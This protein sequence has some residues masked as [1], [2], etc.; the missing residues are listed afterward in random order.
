[1]SRPKLQEDKEFHVS[2]DLIVPEKIVSCDVCKQETKAYFLFRGRPHCEKC[3]Y[4]APLFPHGLPFSEKLAENV[5]DTKQRIENGKASL[6]IIDG[7]IGEGKTTLGVEIAEH[8]QG[9]PLVFTEQLAMGGSDFARRLKDCHKKGHPVVVYDEAGDFNS[10]AALTRLNAVLNRVFET[11]RAFKILVIICLP[12]FHVLDNS[13]L[14]KQIPRFLVHCEKRTQ[15]YGNFGGYSLRRMY[16]LKHRMKKLVIAPSAYQYVNP[17]FYGHFLN[18]SPARA[19]ELDEFS[20]RGKLDVLDLAEI[21]SEGLVSYSNLAGKLNRSQRWVEM[22]IR[23]LS[24][25]P[26]KVYKLQ[27]FYGPE[28]IDILAQHLGGT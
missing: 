11:F 4:R 19:K 7:G 14:E 16:Y 22:K 2:H 28:T 17:N 27:N 26:K 10:R 6:L 20:T 15:K 13:L 21:H 23:E 12:S 25:K 18:L 3:Y 9:R 8:Y 24:I 5:N 1:M